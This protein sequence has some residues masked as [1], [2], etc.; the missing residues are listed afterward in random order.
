MTGPA[1][2]ASGDPELAREAEAALR[3]LQE[4]LGGR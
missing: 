4:M 3:K 2:D 1:P